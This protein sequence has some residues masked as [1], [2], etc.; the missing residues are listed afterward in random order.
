[1]SARRLG[2]TIVQANGKLLGILSDG[3]L[4][5]LLERNGPHAFHKTAA[6]MMNPTPRTIPP[7]T[8]AIDALI[9]MEQRKITSL[10]VVEDGEKGSTPIGVVHL[11]DLWEVAPEPET[12]D[13]DAAAKTELPIDPETTNDDGDHEPV[14]V[15]AATDAPGHNDDRGDD[16]R[17]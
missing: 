8:L 12:P 5:R 15:H 9:L 7:E 16:G 14:L 6:D 3:D 13:E 11:H 10:V 2:M 17:L 1:M 4:R